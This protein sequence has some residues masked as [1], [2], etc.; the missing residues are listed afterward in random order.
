MRIRNNALPLAVSLVLV[1]SL[2]GGCAQNKQAL[3]SADSAESG[4]AVRLPPVEAMDVHLRSERPEVPPKPPLSLT[5]ET[6]DRWLTLFEVTFSPVS[7]GNLPEKGP[8]KE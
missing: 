7:A 8:P 3:R 2:F 5:D 1:V 6:R 4:V